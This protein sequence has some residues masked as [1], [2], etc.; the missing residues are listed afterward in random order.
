LQQWG[1][2]IVDR[3]V[4]ELRQARL[5]HYEQEESEEVRRRLATLVELAACCLEAR[6]ADQILEHA[7]RIAR[8][9]F[10]SGYRLAEVQT[11]I[12]V[13]EESLCRR[14]IGSVPPDEVAG[15][16][17]LIYAIFGIAKDRLAQ[18]YVDL[19]SKRSAGQGSVC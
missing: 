12:N 7:D 17:C 1:P 11:S 14:V 18:T 3:A 15:A 19:A 10:A 4:A 5:E 2:D 8:E 9:R 13:V 16:L 6:R